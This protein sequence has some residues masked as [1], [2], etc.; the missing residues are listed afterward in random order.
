MLRLSISIWVTG[1]N[2]IVQEEDWLLSSYSGVSNGCVL[3]LI[4][5]LPFVVYVRGTDGRMHTIT[6]KSAQPDVRLKIAL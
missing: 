5:L 1:G 3:L 6:V 2:V 4:A